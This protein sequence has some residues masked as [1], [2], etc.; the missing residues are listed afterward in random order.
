M[1]TERCCESRREDTLRLLRAIR[2]SISYLSNP[3]IALKRKIS[4]DRVKG[5]VALEN[6]F[7]SSQ[8]LCL[9][10]RGYDDDDDDEE[11]VFGTTLVVCLLLLL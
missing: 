5:C 1:K 9:W 11:C 7:Y 10:F 8:L 6:F 4:A 3:S 2:Q